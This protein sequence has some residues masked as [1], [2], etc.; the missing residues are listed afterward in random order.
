MFAKLKKKIAEEGGASPR[1]GTARI[2]RSFSRESITSVGA[3]SGDDIASDSSCPREDLLSQLLRRNDQ[4]RKLEVKLSDYAEQLRSLQKTREKLEIALEKHQDSSM[5]KLQEQNE[6]YQI[7]RAKMAEGM[8]LA[9]NKKD[10]EW[11]AKVSDIEKEKARFEEQLQEMKTRSLNLFHRRDEQDELD[12]FQQQEL[13]KVKHMLL[14]K[15]EK[16]S[17]VEQELEER[18][19]ELH[20]TKEQLHDSHQRL[21]NLDKSFQQLQRQIA[22]TDEERE[23]FLATKRNAEEKI[24]ELEKRG[25]ELQDTIQRLSVDLHK[26]SVELEEKGKTIEHLREKAVS[27]QK[28]ME[29]NYSEDEHLQELLKEKCELEQKLEEM[30]QNVLAA[31][32]SQT[33]VTS[34]LEAQIATQAAQLQTLAKHKEEDIQAFREQTASQMNEL[35]QRLHWT[36][37]NLKRRA[38]EVNEKEIQ[39]K[40]MQEDSEIESNKWQQQVAALRHQHTER[41]SRADAQIAALETA[42]EFDKTA[43]QHQIS[44][45]GQDNEELRER[46]KETE[47]SLK[48]VE[49]ELEKSKQ[50]LSSKE[51]ISAEIAKALEETQK[52]RE[53]L[54]HEVAKLT[55]TLNEETTSGSQQHQELL[56]READLEELK[57]GAR[58]EPA[59]NYNEAVLSQLHQLQVE[60]NMYECAT[61][62]QEGSAQNQLSAVRL[63]VTETQAL[64]E[65]SQRKVSEL[66]AEVTALS[67]Q[68]TPSD[69]DETE[70]NGEVAVTDALRLQRDNQ[71]L[72]QQLLEKNKT[73]KQLQQRLSELKKTL[74]KELK[75]KP[76]MELPEVR[77][78]PCSELPCAVGAAT[79]VINN[80]DMNDS[81]EINFEYLKHVLLK[82]M[83]CRESEAF[84]LLKA[85]SMLLNFTLEEENMLKANL[86]YKMWCTWVDWFLVT[87]FSPGVSL[88]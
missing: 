76:E 64:L 34:A 7:S 16:L 62:E 4:V 60:K 65:M 78:R 49:C 45:L 6:A 77:E 8:T 30:R 83:S 55:A 1:P 28:R 74:Q 42:R 82:F 29:G 31:K 69:S 84:Q 81:R 58:T 41:N 9:L 17:K 57:R 33:E 75:M 71:D 68:L 54:Q 66:E 26:T 80:S 47:N 10:Q 20:Q 50:E 63:Q 38:E 35:E 12:G 59:H 25:K 79:T 46:L 14:R 43:S 61:V 13:A 36:A 5:R 23:E 48:K 2:P 70:Q 72:E 73:I 87:D 40:K 11:M 32:T 52:Q 56:K 15:E 3:D 86:E 88:D 85:V 53:D 67:D 44:Q 39:L 21:D 37:E 22:A 18:S 51:T 24:S 19:A 27:L